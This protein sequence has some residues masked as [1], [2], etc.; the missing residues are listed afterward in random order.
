MLFPP[1]IYSEAPV[2][3]NVLVHET[4]TSD[5]QAPSPGEDAKRD[6]VDRTSEEIWRNH[7]M[8]TPRLVDAPVP[9]STRT[10]KTWV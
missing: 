8:H 5:E 10:G 3:P 2:R 4:Q 7:K 9:N 6:F 1:A